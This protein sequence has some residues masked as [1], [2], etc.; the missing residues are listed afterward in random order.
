LGIK[1]KGMIMGEGKKFSLPEGYK[2]GEHEDYMSEMQL[3]YFE[4]KLKEWR[5][6]LEAESRQT[7]E[8]LRNEN[9]K[10]PDPSDVASLAL[11]TGLELRTT[12]RYFKLM[13]KIDDA[14]KRIENGSYGYCEETG[15]PIGIRRLEARP[16][17]TL[18]ITA[19]EQHERTEYSYRSD[20]D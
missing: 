14:I 18:C 3:A 1:D 5:Q 7:V 2:P 10:E 9:W 15:K 4:H 13:D 16:I 19:Q 11:N 20:D 8:K 6:E 12:N 17:A